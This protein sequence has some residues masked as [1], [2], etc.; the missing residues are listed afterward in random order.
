MI[1]PTPPLQEAQDHPSMN[2]RAWFSTL[3]NLDEA[4]SFLGEL[5]LIAGDNRTGA[6]KE[7]APSKHASTLNT[8][9]GTGKLQRNTRTSG[10]YGGSKTPSV[11]VSIVGNWHWKMILMV[12]R[13]LTGNHVA[14]TKERCLYCAGTAAKTHEALPADFELAPGQPRWTWLPLTARLAA[15]RKIKG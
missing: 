3:V 6:S 4:Y 5:G 15:K 7:T 10:S 8:L 12:E 9:I 2:P 1:S 11:N 14:A 13:G